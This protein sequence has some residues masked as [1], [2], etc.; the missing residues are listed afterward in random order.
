M[1]D[2]LIHSDWSVSPGKRWAATAERQAGHWVVEPPA[3]VGPAAAFLDRAFVAVRKQRVL[4]GFDFLIGVPVA[5]G[6]QTGI[7]S[8]RE[9]LPLLGE[10]RWSQFFAVARLPAEIAITRPFYPLSATKG[11]SRAELVAGLGVGSFDELLR[12][13]ERR[14][15]HR[16]AACSLFWTLGGNQVGK[17]A[18]SG[19]QAVIRPALLRG[20]ALWP[21]D[22][23]LTDLSRTSGVVLAETYPAEAYRMV[24][25]GFMPGQ[26]KRRQADRQ[27]K[28]AAI[29]AWAERHGVVFTAPAA[30]ALASGFG[31]SARGEDQFDA[32]LGLL[33]MI[34]VA[35][36]RRAEA[37]ERHDGTAAWEGWILG[38]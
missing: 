6:T 11:V 19:W 1:F 17:G 10:G 30:D 27:E 34:E 15:A 31:S 25:A 24:G 28:A 14:T 20:A 18:L 26:S 2:K 21:F 16:Q 33:K 36:G 12:V 8:F 32:L 7:R 4:L 22:G 9:L 23:N 29:W 5:Y 38:R 37:T 3:L 13:C 35:E